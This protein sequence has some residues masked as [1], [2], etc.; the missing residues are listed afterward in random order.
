V[1]RTSRTYEQLQEHRD[2]CLLGP[3]QCCICA[4][5]R[6]EGL[7]CGDTCAHFPRCDWLISCP[8]ER[9][10]CDWMPSRYVRKTK[11]GGAS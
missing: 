9:L 3:S 10:T 5:M 7:T 8:P 6:A 2:S 1:S 4:T 11:E